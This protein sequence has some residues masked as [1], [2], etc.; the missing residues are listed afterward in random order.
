MDRECIKKHKDV[1][2]AWIGGKEIEFY[3]EEDSK[4]KPCNSP[5]WIKN[6]EYRIKPEVVHYVGATGTSY[7]L[8]AESF[9]TRTADK[10]KVT[11]PD[12][13]KKMEESNSVHYCVKASDFKFLTCKKGIDLWSHRKSDVTCKDCLANMCKYPNLRQAIIDRK[14]FFVRVTPEQ[15]KDVKDIAANL[16]VMFP[17]KNPC[18]NYDENILTFKFYMPSRDYVITI[19]NI[20]KIPT[21]FYLS[22]D[23]FNAPLPE[24]IAEGK[25]CFWSQSNKKDDLFTIKSNNDGMVTIESKTSIVTTTVKSLSPAILRYPTIEE[26]EMLVPF[27]VREISSGEATTIVKIKDRRIQAYGMSSLEYEVFLKLYTKL[28]KTEFG[29]WVKP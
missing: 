9:V 18:P 17:G 13:L 1:F 28:D 4:W 25:K 12:C 8:C 26:L 16:G 22:T 5:E 11:C 3:S 14:E 15:S 20:N 29:E 24:W 19:Q 27:G 21:E 2:E 7:S 10:S 23:S 6:C